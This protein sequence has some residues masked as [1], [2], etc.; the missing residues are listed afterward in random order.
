MPTDCGRRG[1][2]VEDP[3]R[4]RC[5]AERRRRGCAGFQ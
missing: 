2:S 5:E 4:R 3:R 1:L